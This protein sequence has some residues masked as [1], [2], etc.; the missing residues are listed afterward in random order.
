[1]SG[2]KENMKL[3]ESFLGS[4][5]EAGTYDFKNIQLNK[6]LFNRMV[7]PACYNKCANTDVDIVFMNEMECTYKCIITYKQAFTILKHSDME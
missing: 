7:I 5:G 4:M 2:V 6:D 1:M 3:W